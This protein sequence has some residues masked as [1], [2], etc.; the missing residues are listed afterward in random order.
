LNTVIEPHWWKFCAPGSGVGEGTS[1]GD[2]DGDADGEG[3]T[4][5]DVAG[6]GCGF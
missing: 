6:E 3:A 4:L 2:G 1:A 5:G